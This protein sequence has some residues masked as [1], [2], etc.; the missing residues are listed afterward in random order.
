M[1][2]DDELVE[3]LAARDAAWECASVARL[4]DDW[5]TAWAARETFRLADLRVWQLDPSQARWKGHG[6]TNHEWESLL[7]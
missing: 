4:S 6:D 2:D 3:A 7:L 5:Q 1:R